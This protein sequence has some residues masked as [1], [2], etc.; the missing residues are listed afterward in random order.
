[1]LRTG[2]PFI[3]TLDAC[4]LYP[5]SL[6][7][8]L[9]RAAKEQLY[10]PV[11]TQQIWDEVTKNL[12]TRG[13]NPMT[14]TA[15]AHLRAE[16]SKNFDEAFVTNYEGLI[17]AMTNH[18]KDRHVLAAAVRAHAQMI[19]TFDLRHFPEK[20]VS[21]YDIEVQHPDTFLLNLYELAPHTVAGMIDL[22]TAY[23]RG[24]LRRRRQPRASTRRERRQSGHR[25]GRRNP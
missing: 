22:P 3:V 20:A 21:P 11:W 18:R 8:T 23:L 9:L 7:D 19:V 13:P 2:W 6:R 15:A 12:T 25:I 16:V 4:V 17:R 5:A 10:R 1:M 14:A 24:L